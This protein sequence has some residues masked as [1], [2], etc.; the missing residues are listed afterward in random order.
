[1]GNRKEQIEN[2]KN[3][4]TNKQQELNRLELAE[5]SGEQDPDNEDLTQDD[6]EDIV[7]KILP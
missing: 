2:L 7:N 5:Q 3:E 1:M 4:I 6:I